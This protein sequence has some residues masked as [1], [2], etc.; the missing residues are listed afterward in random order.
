[1][2]MISYNAIAGMLPVAVTTCKDRK[3]NQEASHCRGGPMF[4]CY[5]N[6][7][8]TGHFLLG[9]SL[10]QCLHD[11]VLSGIV[12]T[13]VGEIHSTTGHTLSVCISS[14]CDMHLPMYN[15]TLADA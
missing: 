6:K 3:W 12:P 15:N 8:N 13:C 11:G 14:F 10:R 9:E 2:L 5:I 7:S 1:M 4:R